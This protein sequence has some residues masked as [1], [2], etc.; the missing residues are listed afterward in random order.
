MH[1]NVISHGVAASEIPLSRLH[2]LSL[3]DSWIGM[4]ERRETGFEAISMPHN[5]NGPDSD[6]VGEGR[7]LLHEADMGTVPRPNVNR[8]IQEQAWSSP[9]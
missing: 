5:L 4:D 8:F 9:I 3:G 2:S 6:G 7:A 1:G